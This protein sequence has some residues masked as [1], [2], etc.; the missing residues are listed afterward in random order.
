[1]KLSHPARSL[2]TILTELSRFQVPKKLCIL[3]GAKACGDQWRSN[4]SWSKPGKGIK[5]CPKPWWV[6]HTVSVGETGLQKQE[7]QRVRPQ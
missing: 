1:M 4:P 7:T 3:E 5:K 2:V 6:R